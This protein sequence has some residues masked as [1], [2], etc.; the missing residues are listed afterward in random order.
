MWGCD[1]EAGSKQLPW[2]VA[3]DQA[4]YR[5]RRGKFLTQQ[6]LHALQWPRYD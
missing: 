3:Q 5:R 6:N 2:T 1:W 4:F